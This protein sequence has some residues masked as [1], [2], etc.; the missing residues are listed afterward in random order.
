MTRRPFQIAL[1][2]SA[3]L[4][5]V[6]VA[7]VSAAA[8]ENGGPQRFAASLSPVPHAASADGGSDAS[9][10]AFLWLTG[11]D[12]K[13]QLQVSDVSAR[14]PHAMHIHGKDNP[15]VSFCPGAN[16]R[17]GGVSDD[18][19]ETVD[20]LPDYG[21]IQVSF[22]T[23]GDTSAS[24]GLA[25]DRFPVGKSNEKLTYQRTLEIPDEVASRLADK[26]IVVHGQDID[27]DGSYDPGPITALGAPLEA[28]LPVACGE[29]QPKK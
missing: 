22:T 29:I 6:G 1:S 11:D 26:H 3:L 27:G 18:L 13:V 2:A 7:S 5:G 21:P 14:L 25:L 28:E 10:R 17:Q 9:G 20:G 15:E 23:R 24:S 12:L 19:I 4:V 16:R 8:A